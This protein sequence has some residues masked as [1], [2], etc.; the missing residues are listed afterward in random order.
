MKTLQGQ[1]GTRDEAH[2]ESK[3]NHRKASLSP[4]ADNFGKVNWNEM[5]A[6]DSIPGKYDIFL[7]MYD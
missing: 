4:F 1:D 3:C 6:T 7:K 5:M 2:K